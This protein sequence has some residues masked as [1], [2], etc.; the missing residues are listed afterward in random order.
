LTKAGFFGW[1]GWM[2]RQMRREAL[3]HVMSYVVI[4]CSIGFV[5]LPMA[6]AG[7]PVVGGDAVI[8][9]QAGPRRS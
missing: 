3:H 5:M 2:L 1:L 8:R 6:L 4:G 7:A 9:A